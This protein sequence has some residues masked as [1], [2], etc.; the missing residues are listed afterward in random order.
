MKMI[1][2]GEYTIPP[3]SKRTTASYRAFSWE[4][5]RKL[6]WDVRY[7]EPKLPINFPA[8]HVQEKKIGDDS[9]ST[10]DDDFVAIVEEIIAN[11]T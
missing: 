3:P 5:L 1:A 6:G 4:H 7:I 10:V 11:R 9:S 2:F 8:K